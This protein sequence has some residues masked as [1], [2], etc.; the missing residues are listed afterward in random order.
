MTSDPRVEAAAKAI[1]DDLDEHVGGGNWDSSPEEERNNARIC[2]AKAV[3]A[4]DRT[5]LAGAEG[6]VREL[7]EAE[8]TALHLGFIK[9]SPDHARLAITLEQAAATIQA[10]AGRIAELEAGL[11]K[12]NAEVIG[13][14]S[15]YQDG[16]REVMGHTNYSCIQL[17][18]EQARS[19]LHPA[20]E[21]ES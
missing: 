17:R 7:R 19:L 18:S 15:A 16:L 1:L 10:Q 5:A 20:G 12:L 11:A 21:R 3:T 14:L 13:M 4:A 6:V 2:A 9:G 8:S